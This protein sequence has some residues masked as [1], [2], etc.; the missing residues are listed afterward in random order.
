MTALDF[1]TFDD[2]GNEPAKDWAIKDVI[3]LDED[4]S[5]FGMP[6]SL[7]SALLTDLHVHLAS[8]RAWRGHKVKRPLGSVFF[9][10]ERA[11]LTRRRL[12]AYAKRDGL[13]NLPIAVCD[14][15]V[16]MI[17]ESCVDTI[18]DTL[19]A[20]EVRFGV[21][22]G[23]ITFDTYAKGVA[24]GGGDEDKAQHAN[25]VAANM[26]RIHEGLKYPIHIAT[27]GHSGWDGK[28]ERGSSAKLGHVDLSVGIAGDVIRTAKIV[29]ANDQPDGV[30]TSFGVDTIKL[31]NDEDGH[32]L[33][34]GILSA[35]VATV[36]PEAAK[37]T[38]RQREALSA[39]T[40]LGGRAPVEAWREEMLRNGAIDRQAKNPRADWR[41]LR[42]ALV[43]AGL[44]VERDGVVELAGGL[45]PPPPVPSRP[46]LNLPPLP[47]LN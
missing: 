11:G 32:S 18:V 19:K 2:C 5:W 38:P 35:D 26:K 12:A 20:A 46:I 37:V 31:G 36:A 21:P 9:A 10:F 41:R 45:P 23:L 24:A 16:D 29:K 25:I 17:N 3:A 42:S 30:L 6:G 15:I 1:K 4:S 14:Q 34:V 39:L 40:T 13:A 28:H 43:D 27:I 33:T 44:V 8:G 22:V 47:K 7:K